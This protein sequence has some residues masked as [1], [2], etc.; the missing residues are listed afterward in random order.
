V[1]II[2]SEELFGPHASPHFWAVLG[3]NASWMIFPIVIVVRMWGS[4]K[5][6]E[7]KQGQR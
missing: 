5:P 7:E 3:A 2:L 1:T 4:E 6:F